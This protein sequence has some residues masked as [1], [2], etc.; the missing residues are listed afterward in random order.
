MSLLACV[1][2]LLSEDY[3]GYAINPI[4]WPLVILAAVGHLREIRG[5]CVVG[6]G[7]EVSE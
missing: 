3:S 1:D 5:D 2:V 6:E 4:S 7:G